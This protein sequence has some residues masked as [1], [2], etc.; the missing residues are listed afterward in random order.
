MNISFTSSEQFTACKEISLDEGMT[1]QRGLL[2]FRTCSHGEIM[3]YGLVRMVCGA[4]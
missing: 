3:K 2:D 1:L 4:K